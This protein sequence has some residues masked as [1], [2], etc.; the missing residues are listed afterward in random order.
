MID[1]YEHIGDYLQGRLSADNKA[2][3]ENALAENEA[4]RQAVENHELVEDALDLLLE[5]DILGVMKDID[6]GMDDKSHYGKTD[7][8]PRGL[9]SYLIF[10]VL[11]LLTA[12][13]SY[14][15]KQNLQP[16]EEILYASYFKPYIESGE[17]GSIVKI[18]ELRDCDKGHYYMTK[19]EYD[20][21]KSSFNNSIKTKEDCIDKAKWYLALCRIKHG[22]TDESKRILNEIVRNGEGLYVNKSKELLEE[23]ER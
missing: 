7:V 12:L 18:D 3:F 23:L 1:I 2:T 9:K 19:G 13:A 15:I 6:R 5:E 14:L 21:A 11:A 4:L 8:F 16:K 22:E 10:L 20:L 17:R